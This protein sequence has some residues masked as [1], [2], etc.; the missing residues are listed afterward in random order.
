MTTSIPV[1]VAGASGKTGR[2]VGK[3]IAHA[4]DM[5]VVGAIAAHYA[6]S[7]LKDLWSEPVSVILQRN[8]SDIDAP[9]AV[10]VDFTERH[11]S[12][13]RVTE[14]IV[15]GWDIVV[16]TTGFSA[17]ERGSIDSLV[18]Q[19]HVGAVMIANF[20]LGAW[21]MEQ[22]AQQ[23]SR[24]FKKAEVLEAHTDTKKDK[25][26]GTAARMAQILAESWEINA[27]DIPV[28]SI[29]LPG[30]VAHQA[31]V[32]G[33]MGQTLTMRHDVHDRTAYAQ[34]VLAAVRKVSGFRGRVVYDLGEIIDPV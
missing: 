4:P 33:T 7:A 26:S 3:A 13:Q 24:Y 21:V 29:R 14:A 23:A 34:G 10:L 12:Y 27:V 2:E 31:V 25:P 8:L 5:E 20:S 6:G 32:F 28:H 15:R 9:Y 17:D 1:V 30:M 22:L 19:Y 18:R 11:S 16:G